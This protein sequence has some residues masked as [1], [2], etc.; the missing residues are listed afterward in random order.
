MA[1]E[2]KQSIGDR[3]DSFQPSKPMLVWAFVAGAVI[4]AGAGFTLGGWV[5]QSTAEEMRDDARFELAGAVCVDNF[6]SMTDTQ[7]QLE[8]LQTIRSAF[9]RRQFIEAGGWATMPGEETAA[10]RTAE[11]CARALADVQIETLVDEEI[12]DDVAAEVEAIREIEE[13]AEELSDEQN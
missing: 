13:E 6:L 10:R 12:A 9:Q 1:T 2:P 7:A 4:A 11:V 8:Q 3:I 5:T